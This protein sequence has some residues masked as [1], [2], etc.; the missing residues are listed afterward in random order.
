MS[1]HPFIT[2]LFDTC[3]FEIAPV[4]EFILESLDGSVPS[5]RGPKNSIV[6][7]ATRPAPNI[8]QNELWK[9]AQS[10]AIP[11][12]A[13]LVSDSKVQLF[14]YT[15]IEHETL[16]GTLFPSSL[17]TN[18]LA[19]IKIE[20]VP[21]AIERSKVQQMTFDTFTLKRTRIDFYRWLIGLR[22]YE[23]EVAKKTGF[24][25][26]ERKNFK[27]LDRFRDICSGLNEKHYP[28]AFHLWT[29]EVND[30]DYFLTAD[31]KFIKAITETSRIALI[32]RPIA[33]SDFLQIVWKSEITHRCAYVT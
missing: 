21:S 31:K 25:D 33:P 29:A 19:G 3:L 17:A 24:S 2:A 22:D 9:Q 6:R 28:D 15:E 18:S 12:I 10:D 4:E 14:T 8:P 23:D 5:L 16:N 30:L 11:H 1:A 27:S 7:I 20:H 13:Q 32:T 26:F